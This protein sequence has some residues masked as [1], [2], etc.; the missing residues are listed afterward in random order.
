[1]QAALVL[2]LFLLCLPSDVAA[3]KTGDASVAVKS[4]KSLSPEPS[5][6]LVTQ[7]HAEE[8]STE[9]AMEIPRMQAQKLA[10]KKRA[11]EMSL[12]KEKDKTNAKKEQKKEEKQAKN[13]EEKKDEKKVEKKVSL[14]KEKDKQKEKQEGKQETKN[15]KKEQKK[16]EKKEDKNVKK[17][18]EKQAEKK[19]EKRVE[20]K[21]AKKEEKK[22]E[23]KQAKK[24]EKKVEKKQAKKEE[25]KVEKKEEKKEEK[26]AKNKEE[27]KVEKHE[28][29]TRYTKPVKSDSHDSFAC[30]TPTCRRENCPSGNA[31]HLP[32]EGCCNRMMFTMLKDVVGFLEKNDYDYSVNFG[33][34]LGGERDGGIIPWTADTDIIVS[35][36]G[37]AALAK[38]T[39]IPY[40]F[41]PK[42][43]TRN[44]MRA[45]ADYEGTDTRYLKAIGGISSDGDKKHAGQVY[46]YMDIYHDSFIQATSPSL[47][48]RNGDVNKKPQHSYTTVYGRKFKTV[49]DKTGCLKKKYGDYSNATHTDGNDRLTL[50]STRLAIGRGSNLRLR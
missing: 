9:A 17:K 41:I 31:T 39:E 11:K 32:P 8:D 27:K 25:K 21:Q 29:S 3:L 6:S 15:E 13:K 7:K 38:Q 37:I 22:V 1:M 30:R 50:A 28:F 2:S 48:R 20:K 35:P 40:R 43:R 33:T 45:C 47:C 12:K 49:H 10:Q 14:T 46:Y 36:E 44:I 5:N 24:E 18:E 16:V 23:K 4:A 19:E 42:D 26:Q 34:L